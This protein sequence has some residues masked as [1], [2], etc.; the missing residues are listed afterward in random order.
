MEKFNDTICVSIGKGD[1][2]QCLNIINENNLA[3]LRLDMLNLSNNEINRLIKSDCRIIATFRPGNGD[4]SKSKESLLNAIRCGADYVDIEKEANEEYFN[5][6]YSEAKKNNCK[7]IVSYHNYKHTPDIDKLNSIIA[8]C[9][10]LNADL[11]KIATFIN[12][13]ADLSRLL[14]LY[15]KHDNIIAV[16]MGELG[17]I[18]RIAAAELGSAFTYASPDDSFKTASGQLSKK[19][20]LHIKRILYGIDD[21]QNN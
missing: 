5:D 12:C 21:E 14:S 10:K 16:G 17:K 1:F 3:E 8:S 4:S 2:E 6:I 19:E 18:S 9:K 15:E 7:L 20:Y 13:P 11:V